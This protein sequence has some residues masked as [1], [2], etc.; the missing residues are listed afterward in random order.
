MLAI[1]AARKAKLTLNSEIFLYNRCFQ[2]FLLLLVDHAE[3]ES[4]T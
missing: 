4:F 1:A 3:K 2:C